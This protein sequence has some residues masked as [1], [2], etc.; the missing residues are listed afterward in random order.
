MDIVGSIMQPLVEGLWF[1]ALGLSSLFRGPQVS[2]CLST[3][4]PWLLLSTLNAAPATKVGISGFPQVDRGLLW[5]PELLTGLR[6][7]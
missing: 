1:G 2:P 5:L 7:H 3:A 4:T 6:G